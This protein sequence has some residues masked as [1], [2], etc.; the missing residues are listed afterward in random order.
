RRWRA[1]GFT[2]WAALARARNRQGPLKR[3]IAIGFASS[4]VQSV[5]VAAGAMDMAVEQL[6]FGGRSHRVHGDVEM[7]SHAG[8]WVV[9]VQ[10]HGIAFDLGD[11][12]GDLP[13]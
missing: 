1:G 10:S 6:L 2:P 8:Q 9:A 11:Y 4:W 12:H 13:L 5:V 3:C 7:Q